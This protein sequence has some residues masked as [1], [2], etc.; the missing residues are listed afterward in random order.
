MKK[1]ILLALIL[2]FSTSAYAL[3]ELENPDLEGNPITEENSPGATPGG[4]IQKGKGDAFGSIT[5]NPPTEDK[6]WWDKSTET[7][8]D[9]WDGEDD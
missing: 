3:H 2:A 8:G 4:E 5:E 6:S 1:A 9:W 7:I